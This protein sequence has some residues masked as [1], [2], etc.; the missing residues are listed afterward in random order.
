MGFFDLFKSSKKKK[1]EEILNRLTR[2][3][4]PEGQAQTEQDAQVIRFLLEFRYPLETIF[5][6]YIHT[7]IMY[8]QTKDQDIVV[9][10][11]LRQE[12]CPLSKQDAIFIFNY[13]K[14]KNKA[15][16]EGSIMETVRSMK[17]APDAEKIFSAAKGTKVSVALQ[18]VPIGI[19]QE[20]VA[21]F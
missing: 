18:G 5:K 12:G 17:G 7:R 11:V 8:S 19:S 16:A 15:D 13:V 1:E 10:S 20:K 21:T 3:L 9:N 4:F 6:S 2:Q 14:G